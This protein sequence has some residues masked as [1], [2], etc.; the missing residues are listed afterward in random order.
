MSFGVAAA[1]LLALVPVVV[2]AV[3][4]VRAAAFWRRPQR[5]AGPP[6][7]VLVVR[8]LAGA[9]ALLSPA[10][11]RATC[12]F[13]VA[14]RDDAAFPAAEAACAALR[15]A[16]SD[17]EVVLTGGDRGLPN[18]KAAQL[19]FCL[20]RAGDSFDVLVC[21]DGDV[22]LEALEPLL[23]PLRWGAAATWAPPVETGAAASFGDRASHAL[24]GGSLHAFP[25]LAGIDPRGLVGKLFAV[26]VE[27][28]RRIGG[29]EALARYLGEDMELARRL[30]AAGERIEAVPLRARSLV[31]GRSLATV[32]DRYHRWMLVIRAQRP[33]LLASYPLLFAPLPGIVLAGLVAGSAEAILLGVCGRWLTAL[34]ARHVAHR[35]FAP[36][37]AAVDALLADALLFAALVRA[38]ASRQLAWRGRRLSLARDGTLQVSRE[39][40]PW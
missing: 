28:L 3:A 38:L 9:D 5:Q 39:P 6:G 7:H 18:H 17:A 36:F 31:A 33:H 22:E 29:F 12:W 2:G 11:P 23:A 19:A 37:D 35:R 21:A 25:L 1:L 20:E 40:R 26:R 30:L 27:P 4:W 32:A 15:A 16:G 10:H 8:P 24:L 14:D 13:A 34:A